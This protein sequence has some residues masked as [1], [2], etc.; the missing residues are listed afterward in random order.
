MV[1]DPLPRIPS[2]SIFGFL[3]AIR[4]MF[5]CP[6]FCKHAPLRHEGQEFVTAERIL[7]WLCCRGRNS[8]MSAVAVSQASGEISLHDYSTFQY[9]LAPPSLAVRVGD[10]ITSVIF[11]DGPKQLQDAGGVQDETSAIVNTTGYLRLSSYY[12]CCLLV[13]PSHIMGMSRFVR[14]EDLSGLQGCNDAPTEE[15]GKEKVARVLRHF[16]YSYYC[17]L[18]KVD[19]YHIQ[20]ANEKAGTFRLVEYIDTRWACTYAIIIPFY[21]LFA[22]LLLLF[23]VPLWLFLRL[24]ACLNAVSETCMHP[25]KIQS[26]AA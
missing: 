11:Y 3:C 17:G 10:Q 8:S 18:L 4:C 26:A 19:T 25:K 2:T 14:A 15:A 12:L 13:L 7:A 1:K 16:I 9:M 6:G 20:D 22:P 21:V 5:E 23:S 24:V